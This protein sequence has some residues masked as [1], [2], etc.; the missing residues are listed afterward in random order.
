MLTWGLCS[1]AGFWNTLWP[2]F[3][4]GC[5]LTRPMEKCLMAAKW[6]IVDLQTDLKPQKVLA[7]IWGRL[8]K[9]LEE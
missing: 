2:W 8:R 7:R 4:G 5:S 1:R 6:E 3:V 9:P